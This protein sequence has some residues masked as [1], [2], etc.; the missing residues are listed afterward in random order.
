[1]EEQRSQLRGA[2]IEAHG[3]WSDSYEDL[4]ALNLKAA[5]VL[6]YGDGISNRVI[7]SLGDLAGSICPQGEIT[8]SNG[9]VS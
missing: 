4:L 7:D 8:A 5:N 1:M 6:G 9:M 2:W 3:A